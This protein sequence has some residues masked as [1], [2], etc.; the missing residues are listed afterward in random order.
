M[1]DTIKLMLEIS[2]TILSIVVISYW[3]ARRK[4]K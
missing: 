2:T 3:I 1:F 4:K